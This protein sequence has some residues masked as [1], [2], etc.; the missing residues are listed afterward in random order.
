MNP[1]GGLIGESDTSKKKTDFLCGF[2]A[3]SLDFA[4]AIGGG[5]YASTDFD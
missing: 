4:W 5:F 3:C 2:R 1:V